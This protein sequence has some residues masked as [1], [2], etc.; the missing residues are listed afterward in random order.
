MRTFVAVDISDAHVLDSL[1]ALQSSLKIAAKPVEVKNM[2]FTLMFLGEITDGA[3]QKVQSQLKTIRFEPF[4]ISFEGVGAFPNPRAPRVVWVG[5]DPDGGSKLVSLAKMVEEALSPL[6]FS[7]DKPFKPHATL[8]RIKNGASDIRNELEKYSS[9]KFGV[10]KISEIKF[11]KSVLTP[12]G[13]TY[14]DLEVVMA[15]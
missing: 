7:S 5:L 14:S 11:K 8:F 1:K 10:Q 2:H 6:G 13:P 15:R 4:D 3:A 9:N 12:S